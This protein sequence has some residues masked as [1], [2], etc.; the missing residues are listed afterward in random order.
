MICFESCVILQS[1]HLFGGTVVTKKIM[2][3]KIVFIYYNFSWQNIT[4]LGRVEIQVNNALSVSL[5]R[6]VNVSL[7]KLD[8]YFHFENSNEIL[9]T[10]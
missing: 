1:F 3:I 8:V 9:Q 4:L 5:I 2:T 10:V 7:I 6:E